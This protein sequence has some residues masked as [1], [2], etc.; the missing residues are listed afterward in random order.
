LTRPRSEPPPA[1]VVEARQLTT[2][3]DAT[4]SV[5]WNRATLRL[6][7]DTQLRIDSPRTATLIRGAIYYANERPGVAVTIHTPFGDVQ[8][9]RHAL[10]SSPGRR[11]VARTRAR[12]SG[13][14]ARHDRTRWNGARRRPRVGH[15]ADHRHE[16]RGM[17]VDRERGAAD[18]ARREIARRTVLR[19]I[20]IEKGLTLERSGP[21]QTL[22]GEV[23]LSVSEALDAATAAAG[24]AY[25]IEGDRLIVR[26]RLVIRARIAHPGSDHRHQHCSTPRRIAS[27]AARLLR[28]CASCSRADCASSTARMSSPATMVVR[29]GAA[30]GAAAEDPRRAA[31]RA[32]L[33]SRAP[34]RAARC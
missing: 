33:A 7:R 6:D 30:C 9:R 34:A 25:R 22:H 18:R 27:R 1:P 3:A 16:R 32:R 4:T 19:R 24:V 20:A 29:D 26:G 28:G 12:R 11:R 31:A 21:D 13:E 2:P 17:G 23:P 14:R 8:R 10:R 15:V 5:D